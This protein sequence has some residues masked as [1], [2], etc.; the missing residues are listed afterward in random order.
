[1]VLVDAL[2]HDQI[3]AGRTPFLWETAR[4]GSLGATQEVLAGQLRPAFFAGLWPNES[5]VG[6]L[7][8]YDPSSSPFRAARFVPPCVDRSPRAAW[9]VR[10][11]L[12]AAASRIEARRG[13]R[14]SSAYCYLAEIPTSRLPLFA[15]SE[16]ELPW[17][18]RTLP[19]PGLL[20][21]LS[22]Q[23]IPWLHLGYPVID[24]RTS[25]LTEAALS[26]MRGPHRMVFLHYAELDWVGHEHG[27]LGDRADSTLA[28]ID[29]SLE[30]VWRHA[31][32][33]WPC[34]RLLVFGD[35][36]MVPVRGE[37]DV[38]RALRELPLRHGRD[39]AVF[40]DSTV[41][42]FWFLTPRARPLIVDL[43]AALPGGRWLTPAD[44]D[45]L[46][47]RG[48][49]RENGEAFWLLDEGLVIMPSYFQ[50]EARPAGMH[51]YHPSVRDNW[52]AVVTAD[53]SGPTHAVPLTEVFPLAL[54]MLGLCP[55]TV[56]P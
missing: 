42:R 24:Q 4:T 39:Y 40:L 17:E 43:L 37:V 2:R 7:F 45:D 9:W 32:S 25:F 50:R 11:G 31:A 3:D 33:L 30:K 22:A 54:G 52:G 10:R 38:L 23:G 46:H 20:R 41:A 34:A 29:R 26:R 47:L 53:G 18:D 27:P 55:G 35:H 21:I 12:R 51:G 44:M 8:S 16:T 14:G 15:F 28:A 56:L 19:R 6:H 13:H 49:R 5:G 48:T 36:G 1:M